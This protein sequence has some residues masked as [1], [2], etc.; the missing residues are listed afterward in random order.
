MSR[1][2][3]HCGERLNGGR[4]PVHRRCARHILLAPEGAYRQ[5]A[6]L[7]ER[8]AVVAGLLVP[9]PRPPREPR[10]PP[11]RPHAPIR[12]K[13]DW[14]VV[15]QPRERQS[16]PAPVAVEAYVHT[17]GKCAKCHKR[18]RNKGRLMHRRCLREALEPPKPKPAPRVAVS[19]PASRFCT[20]CRTLDNS[21]APAKVC[22]SCGNPTEVFDQVVPA[23]PKPPKRRRRRTNG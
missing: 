17:P 22:R 1:R 12:P 21:V 3:L 4:K 5:L 9:V 8:G 23:A 11:A 10:R 16:A 13:Y 19:Y 7:D 18:V 15:L 2:C 14:D 20:V 6:L